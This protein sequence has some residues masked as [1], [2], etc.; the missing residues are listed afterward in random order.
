MW[1]EVPQMLGSTYSSPHQAVSSLMALGSVAA[2]ATTP[3]TGGLGA[4]IGA[5][6]D[7]AAFPFQINSGY[8]ENYAESGDK[9]LEQFTELLGG[10]DSDRY[11]RIM[12]EAKRRS[13]AYWKARGMDEKTIDEKING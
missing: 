13:R 12:A 6:L 11:K 3:F 10:Q 4:A 9:R 8:A 7:V 2:Y 1:Y 5:G